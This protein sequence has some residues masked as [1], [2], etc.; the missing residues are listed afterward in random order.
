MLRSLVYGLQPGN[1][2]QAV[3]AKPTGGER[4]IQFTTDTEQKAY[5]LEALRR[6][7][8][9]HFY[10]RK[11]LPTQYYSRKTVYSKESL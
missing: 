3:H 6:S 11:I 5:G 10:V 7:H 9:V 4:L 8:C 1:P 2:E